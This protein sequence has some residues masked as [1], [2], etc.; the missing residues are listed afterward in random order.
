MDD[1]S[2]LVLPPGGACSMCRKRRKRCDAGKPICGPCIKNKTSDQCCYQSL[3]RETK[4]SLEDRV[5]ELETHIRDLEAAQSSKTA[6]RKLTT[7]S[8]PACLLGT[9]SNPRT[10][11][12]NLRPLHGLT[13]PLDTPASLRYPFAGLLRQRQ[14]LTNFRDS[15]VKAFI[16][17]RWHYFQE[18]SIPRFWSAYGLPPSHPESLHPALLD[19]MCLLGCMHT[20]GA[21]TYENLFYARLQRSLC[22]SLANADRLHDFMRASILGGV[23]CHLRRRYAVAGQNHICATIHLAMGCG[24]HQIDSY[25]LYSSDKRSLLSPSRDLVDLGD[26]IHTWWGLYA[27][28]RITSL[29]LGTRAVIPIHEASIATI[30]PC[31]LDEYASGVARRAAYSCIEPLR[32][33]SAELA[34]ITGAHNNVYT[35]RTISMIMLYQATAVSQDV[36]TDRACDLHASIDAVSQLINEMTSYRT[37]VCPAFSC[38]R[39]YEDDGHDATL[40]F[41][42]FMAYAAMIQLLNRA[43]VKDVESW[44]H[45]LAAAQA[46]IALGIEVRETDSSL[47]HGLTHVSWC[48]SYEILAWEMIRLEAL[49]DTEGAAAARVELDEAMGLI[50]WLVQEFDAIKYTGHIQNLARF[51]VH[52]AELDRW[53]K[54]S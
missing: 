19:A 40:I 11:R 39:E 3:K 42:L 23:Y 15:L 32:T 1:G 43:V 6:P 36:S 41:A 37:R 14:M 26:R 18:W 17:K 25:V 48:S 31:S 4:K 9:N 2:V 5:K 20:R 45:R 8:L 10:Q 21:H 13:G 52:T 7:V 24:L 33:H 27:I 34:R 28:D 50:R 38:T 49:G 51:N 35:F 53:R 12:P 29:V 46:C 54:N 16:K 47:L 22:D 30:L 44:G